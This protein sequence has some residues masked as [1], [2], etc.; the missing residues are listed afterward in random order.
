MVLQL[1]IVIVTNWHISTGY[2][3]IDRSYT[4]KDEM[5]GE[6]RGMF[7]FKSK[8]VKQKNK[9]YQ[10]KT[11]KL[12]SRRDE[13]THL[14]INSNSGVRKIKGV[15]IESHISRW[16]K[17]YWICICL[18][19]TIFCNYITRLVLRG[20]KWQAKLAQAS[21]TIF[22]QNCREDSAKLVGLGWFLH[23][24][25]SMWQLWGEKKLRVPGGLRW[26]SEGGGSRGPWG[27]GGCCLKIV[28]ADN[29]TTSMW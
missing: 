9:M 11:H 22:D 18:N 17:K 24:G 25:T 23:I 28:H 27:H 20:E 13:M 19:K 1:L 21:R 5:E 14:G 26:W 4:V 7:C 2:F 12:F 10:W 29:L 6:G 15:G 8:I 3:D 16:I